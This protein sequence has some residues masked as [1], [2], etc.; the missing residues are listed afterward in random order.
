MVNGIKKFQKYFDKNIIDVIDLNHQGN[1]RLFKVSLPGKDYLLK[2][3]SPLH[4]DGWPRGKSEFGAM[5]HLWER[6]F[7]EIPQP[8]GFWE[9]DNVGVYSFEEGDIIDAK[10]VCEK[11]ILAAGDF[12]LKLHK[13]PGKDKKLFGPASSACLSFGGYLDTIKSRFSKFSDYVPEGKYGFRAR[14][15]IDERV[16]PALSDLENWLIRESSKMN[17]DIEK[18]LPIEKQVLT[19]I[20]FGFHNILKQEG[21]GGVK[22]RYKFIDFEYFGR[23]DPIRQ[24]LEFIHH[25]NSKNIGKNL[26]GKFID[27]YKE[28]SGIENFDERA[29]LADPLVRMTWAIICLHPLSPEHMKHLKMNHRK[30]NKYF[31]E[32]VGKRL[33]EAE[34]RLDELY[35]G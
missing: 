19:P 10:S 27:Y 3:Y 5:S 31:E 20:D 17:V 18:V 21:D 11:D 30:D 13:L 8:I 35:H 25:G 4:M 14:Q 1:N 22:D 7:R 34:G 32:L 6:D 23:D 24:V 33:N 12:L 15:F 16:I 9:G 28:N 26:K 2:K 29:Y